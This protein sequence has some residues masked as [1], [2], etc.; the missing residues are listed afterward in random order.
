MSNLQQRLDRAE[1]PA[2]PTMGMGGF[3]QSAAMKRSD[4]VSKRW[5]VQTPPALNR[6]SS[7][8]SVR[9]SLA[10]SQSMPRLEVHSSVRGRMSPH[11]PAVVRTPS[12]GT[13]SVMEHS[14][15]RE[16]THHADTPSRVVDTLSD[17]IVLDKSHPRPPSSVPNLSQLER[18]KEE[19]LD[20]P[21]SPSKRWSPTKS[22]WLESALSK[23]ES[24]TPKAATPQQPSWMA[25]LSKTKQRRGSIDLGK[26]KETYNDGQLR[27]P[28]K[29]AERLP[30]SNL[31]KVE[32]TPA[33]RAQPADSTRPRGDESQRTPIDQSSKPSMARKPSGAER[34][35]TAKPLDALSSKA[36]NQIQD[37]SKPL[38]A[39]SIRKPSGQAVLDR[40]SQSKSSPSITEHKPKPTTPPTKDLRAGLKH[41]GLSTE[42]KGKDE[43]EFQNIFGR[44]RRTQTEKR[45]AHKESSDDL[46]RQRTVLDDPDNPPK[47]T[48]ADNVSEGSD[49]KKRAVRTDAVHAS[50]SGE[51]SVDKEK[52]KEEIP[53]A[54]VRKNALVR[55][56]SVREAGTPL[57]KD[58]ERVAKGHAAGTPGA[59]PNSGSK[60]TVSRT[61]MAK[62]SVPQSTNVGALSPTELF[63]D[64]EPPKTSLS[65]SPSKLASRFNPALANVLAR[66]PPSTALN[67]IKPSMTSSYLANETVSARQPA[68]EVGPDITT[69][70]LTHMTK[71]RAK[72]PKRRL[73][74]AQENKM[75]HDGTKRQTPEYGG[76]KPGPT[77]EAQQVNNDGPKAMRISRAQLVK[78]KDV[79]HSTPA[80][81]IQTEKA[82]TRV[83]AA[84]Q[85][86]P[87][88][89]IKSP[90]LKG[91]PLP[92]L[93]K[94]GSLKSLRS[95]SGGNPSFPRRIQLHPS[96]RTNRHSRTIA[97]ARTPSPNPMD[98]R[99][100]SR[101]Y[102]RPRKT[103]ETRLSLNK[104]WKALVHL[105]R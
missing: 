61:P 83:V 33:S 28:G 77:T 75:S 71:D 95:T 14:K 30:A 72:G 76:E 67:D 73:P 65:T 62:L 44:L 11:D 88:A 104:A 58:N 66:G 78:D 57:A 59:A 93:K 60:P 102:H 39:Y 4:S 56:G 63:A 19:P 70:G 18:S 89:P 81:T 92:P 41:R 29:E 55:S 64:D 80:S 9:S 40:V 23:P 97:S 53:E 100:L 68:E 1:R 50:H 101:A 24:P 10:T 17:T 2:S 42:A 87:L 84:E 34:S 105:L 27:S 54:I 52:P 6:A 5:S 43:L 69:K 21:S 20:R 8:A 32:E 99:P 91:K 94:S 47:A 15:A 85:S 22:S 96:R 16:T 74:T 36:G 45:V 86:L 79:L 49:A 12:P 7:S 82:L 98:S 13:A 90:Q 31:N 38:K 103:H 3:V 26:A 35:T 48:V 37:S 46:I 51:R 25:E